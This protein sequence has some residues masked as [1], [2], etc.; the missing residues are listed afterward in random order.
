MAESSITGGIRPNQTIETIIAPTEELNSFAFETKQ[1]CKL[2]RM[3]AFGALEHDNSPDTL[4]DPIHSFAQ[5][6]IDRLGHIQEEAEGIA[7]LLKVEVSS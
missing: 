6:L 7:S 5:V 1:A 4:L 3:A 2:L